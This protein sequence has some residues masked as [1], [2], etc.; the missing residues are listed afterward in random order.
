MA[1]RPLPFPKHHVSAQA[2][3]RSL[4]RLN[5]AVQKL[6]SILD[7][8]VLL[9]RFVNDI[10]YAFG[11]LRTM[12][13]LREPG[14]D[15][16][17]L[18]AVTGCAQSAVKPRYVIGRDGLVG[19]TAAIG[20]PIYTPDVSKE[21]RY[22]ACESR[23]T[24]SE[25]DLPLIAHGEVIGVF[26]AEHPELDGFPEEQRALLEAL[27]SH[28]AVAIENAR[29]FRREQL[30][31]QLLK[32]QQEEAHRIQQAQFPQAPPQTSGVLV[33][34]QCIPAGAVGGDFYDFIRLPHHG[35]PASEENSRE[36]GAASAPRNGAPQLWGLVLADVAGKGLAAALLMSAARGILRSVVRHVTRPGAVLERVNRV[37]RGD[38]PAQKFVTMV[39]A[40]LDVSNRTLTFA[41]AGHPWPIYSD[42]GRPRFLKTKKGLPLGVGESEYDECTVELRPGS[43][44]LLYSDGV[45]EACNRAE[46][47]YGLERLKLQ[48]R[49][50]TLSAAGVLADVN[51]FSGASQLED[52]ATVLV[53]KAPERQTA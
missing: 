6:N 14:S 52:D 38:L 46:E 24:K 16:L 44:L 36:A 43:R 34:G 28:L 17:Y 5:E 2:R 9:D 27:A 20:M 30:E 23:P 10:A 32:A 29:M 19:Y 48:L 13:L 18:A 41:N 51:A 33:E 8:D 39:Y 22:L 3:V 50:P 11:C 47:E 4:L 45:S 40:V 53:V 42:G 15:E 25:L 12:V 37:M 1:S 21:P 26:N 49:C 31:K 35:K 7:L